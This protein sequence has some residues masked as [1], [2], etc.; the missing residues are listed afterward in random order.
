MNAISTHPT[1]TPWTAGQDALDYWLDVDPIDVLLLGYTRQCSRQRTLAMPPPSLP[2][3]IIVRFEAPALEDMRAL[4]E[5]SEQ[6][7]KCFAT[8][9]TRVRHQSRS[10]PHLFYGPVVRSRQGA[11]PPARWSNMRGMNFGAGA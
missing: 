2:S 11:A 6:D 9:R 4:G 1:N 10:L 7:E 8:T 3:A 5:N